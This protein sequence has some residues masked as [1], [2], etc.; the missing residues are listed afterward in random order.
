MCECEGCCVYPLLAEPALLRSSSARGAGAGGA[1]T[2]LAITPWVGIIRQFSLTFVL[3]FGGWLVC[4]RPVRL[5]RVV[6]NP[7][8]RGFSSQVCT[9]RLWEALR[10]SW[11]KQPLKI[12]HAFGESCV[13]PSF[14]EAA[15]GE[16][17]LSAEKR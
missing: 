12:I 7:A 14:A 4:G 5:G 16:V 1:G 9:A 15:T 11:F 13:L 8:V 6:S 3:S 10:P 17:E 2:G